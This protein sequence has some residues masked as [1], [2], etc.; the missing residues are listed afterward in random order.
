MLSIF[1][2]AWAS[3]C[4]LWRNVYLD[5]LFFWI[6]LLFFFFT[7]SCMSCLYILEFKPLS[8][9]SFAN[10]FFHSECC[11]FVLIMVSILCLIRSHLF[12]FGFIFITLGGGTKK[13]L[14]KFMSEC[15][16]SMFLSKSFIVSSLTFRSLIHFKFIFMSGIDLCYCF[17][18]FSFNY[19]CYDLYD[20]FSF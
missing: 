1:P 17:F 20:F 9:T 16:L 8:A 18:H 7:L 5:L 4:L 12:I 2:C 3:V 6:E 10:I 19:F 13:T 14:L 11:L 15:V